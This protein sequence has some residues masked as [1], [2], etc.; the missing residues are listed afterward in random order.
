MWLAAILT[1]RNLLRGGG[2]VGA[3]AAVFAAQF[4]GRGEIMALIGLIGLAAF[5]MSYG[6]DALTGSRQAREAREF[7]RV[8][9]WTYHH[10][11]SGL[12]GPLGTPPFDAPECSFSHVVQGSFGGFECYDGVYEWRFRVDRD[13]TISGRHRVAVVKLADELPRVMVM[14]DGVGTRLASAFNGAESRFESSAFNRNWRVLA[15][16]A[17]IAHDLLNPRVLDKL[18]QVPTRAPMLFE[19]GLGVRI[20][21]DSEGLGSLADRLGT[22]LAV[23]RFMPEHTIEDHGRLANSIG[24]LPSV[25]TPGAFTGGY[26]PDLWEQDAE[27]LRTAKPRKAQRWIDAARRGKAL[28]PKPPSH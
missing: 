6:L 18:S 16:D 14:P 21:D 26:K 3:I 12:L 9:G 11:L 1:P 4:G 8:H 13:V 10:T 2:A 15:D 25:V 23:A 27:F 24:P 17:R 5:G 28:E 7:A 22:V 19:R 20:D